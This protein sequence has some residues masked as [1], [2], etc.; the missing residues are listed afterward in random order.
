M[1]VNGLIMGKYLFNRV[2]HRAYPLDAR[3]LIKK[4]QTLICFM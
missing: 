3:H 1:G 4:N 2:I